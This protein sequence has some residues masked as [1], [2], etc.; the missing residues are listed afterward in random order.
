MR[1]FTLLELMVVVAIMGLL[2]TV[3]IGGYQQMQRGMEGRG[4]LEN[5][6]SF[7]RAAYERAQIDR[8]PTFVYFWN[9]LKREATDEEPAIVVG[10]AVAVRGRGR[11]SRLD[12]GASGRLL[13]DEFGDLEQYDEDGEY[14]D[15]RSN[16]STVRLYQLDGRP[17]T[18]K[19]STVRETPV[20]PNG[21]NGGQ[22]E[23]YVTHTPAGDGR[24]IQFGYVETA[25][26][27]AN[28]KVGSVYGLEFLSIELPH[29]YVFGSS[30]PN[31]MG[32]PVVDAGGI[33]CTVGTGTAAGSAGTIQVCP[34]NG[35]RVGKAVGTS[36]NPAQQR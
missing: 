13:I 14:A 15:P 18:P 10:R 25:S 1:G 7:M 8:Q 12:S 27:G 22:T 32:Q 5:V 21:N 2:G 29:G 35:S 28:W 34:M 9:E 4:A 26:Q 3:S 6:N 16:D 17:T 19:Y 24:I 36:T 23:I 20:T 31:S 11:I 30:V 33:V